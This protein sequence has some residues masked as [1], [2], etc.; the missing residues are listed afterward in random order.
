[1]KMN[2]RDKY[3]VVR[4][5]DTDKTLL[6]DVINDLYEEVEKTGMSMPDHP[7]LTYCYKEESHELNNDKDLMTMISRVGG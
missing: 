3:V 7:V 2:Y 1:M 4:I 5:E 6:I